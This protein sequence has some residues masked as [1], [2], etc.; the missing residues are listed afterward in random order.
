LAKGG[1]KIAHG[2]L[3]EKEK[4]V[5]A[6]LSKVISSRHFFWPN[7]S[8]SSESVPARLIRSLGRDYQEAIDLKA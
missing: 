4:G 2:Y 8:D 1:T 7:P 5:G 3:W 6:L